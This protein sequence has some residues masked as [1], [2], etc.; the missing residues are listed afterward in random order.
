MREFGSQVKTISA[1]SRAT[2]G[3]TPNTLEI[4]TRRM[5]ARGVPMEEKETESADLERL[6]QGVSP[7]DEP[8]NYP[9]TVHCATCRR[10]FCDAHAEDEEWHPCMLPPGEEGVE[11]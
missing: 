8:C 7:N 5:A 9:A 4:D 11:A 3:P 1:R 10:W 2:A 6:C